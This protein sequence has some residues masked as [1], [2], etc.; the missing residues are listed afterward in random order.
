MALTLDLTTQNGLVV[1]NAYCRVEDINIAKGGMM[2]FMLSR[3]V[4][5]GSAYPSFSQT[6]YSTQYDMAGANVYKQA[7]AHL[8]TLDEFKTA[9]DV[10]EAGQPAQ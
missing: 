7:Y 10:W 2:A 3:Y 1:N 4:A 9:T 8:K 6:M 5:Q